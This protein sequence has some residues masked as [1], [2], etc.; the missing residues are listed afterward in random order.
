[1]ATAPFWPSIQ[2][3]SL[4]RLGGLAMAFYLVPICYLVLAVLM[5]SLGRGP[6]PSA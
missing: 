5:I 1:V 3:H 2:S 6:K 4:D